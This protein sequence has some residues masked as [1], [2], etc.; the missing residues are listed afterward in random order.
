VKSLWVGLGGNGKE[1]TGGRGVWGPEKAWGT[2]RP[3]GSEGLKKN[4]AQPLNS[5]KRDEE[6][7]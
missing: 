5:K 2:G 3:T 1:K 4:G 6:E 7:A